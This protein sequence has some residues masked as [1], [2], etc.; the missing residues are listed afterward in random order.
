MDRTTKKVLL[1][2]GS[3]VRLCGIIEWSRVLIWS[4]TRAAD[5][6]GR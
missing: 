3:G 4:V 1:G 2:L 5:E 6:G